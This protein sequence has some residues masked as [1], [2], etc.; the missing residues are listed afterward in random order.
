M[1]IYDTSLRYR[2]YRGTSLDVFASAVLKLAKTDVTLRSGPITQSFNQTMVIPL[3]GFSGSYRI[4]EGLGLYGSFK[5][6]DLDFQDQA[7]WVN[8]WEMG[9]FGELKGKNLGVDLDMSAGFRTLDLEIEHMRGQSGEVLL[10]LEH[11]GPFL[12]ASLDF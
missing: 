4:K 3:L 9:F 10:D 1:D 6:L 2:L 5:I 11:S 8:D 12:E 7:T